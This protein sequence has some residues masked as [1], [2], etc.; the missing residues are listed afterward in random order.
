MYHDLREGDLHAE[1]IE[2]DFD[3]PPKASLCPE[4]VLFIAVNAKPDHYPAVRQILNAHK[5]RC[6][7][8]QILIRLIHFRQMIPEKLF[9]FAN[10]RPIAD[11]NIRQCQ[12][13]DP[14]TILEIADIRIVHHLDI[15]ARILQ[16]CG[17]DAD[18][19]HNAAEII[20]HDD[21]SDFVLS[22]KDDEKT[23]NDILDQALGAKAYDQS[24]DPCTGKYSRGINT[25]N[26]EAPDEG[27]D[28]G[29]IP[30]QARQQDRNGPGVCALFSIKLKD[31]TEHLID[32]PDDGDCQNQR[33]DMRHRDPAATLD[34]EMIRLQIPNLRYR[35]L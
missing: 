35:F 18:A 23:G 33:C 21:I 20:D 25:E 32:Q 7:K 14:R 34:Q 2:E 27:N 1:V 17:A 6:S 13:G 15:S 5:D 12:R 16:R 24:D 30:E 26:T 10:I 4:N 28:D 8:V 19:A 22:F 29:Q 31:Q 9:Q 11:G 3:I